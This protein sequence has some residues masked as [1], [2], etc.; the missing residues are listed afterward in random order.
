MLD[1]IAFEKNGIEDL[2]SIVDE[3]LYTYS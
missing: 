1:R 3:D 2:R